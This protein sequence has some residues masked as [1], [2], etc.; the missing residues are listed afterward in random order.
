MTITLWI[1]N[2]I[3]AISFVGSGLMKIGRAKTSLVESGLEWADGFSETTV[4]L[5]GAVEFL[6]ALGLILPKSL[7]IAP[8]LT[9]VAAI[10][11]TLVMIGATVTHARREEIT[12]R[13]L[14][15]VGLG[16]LAAASAIL[17]FA[18]L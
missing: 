14:P 18:T 16:I 7:N 2:I 17:G 4:K 9:P 12:D 15:A 10:C 13:G 6:G 1:I 11:L 5:I 8:V 3:L